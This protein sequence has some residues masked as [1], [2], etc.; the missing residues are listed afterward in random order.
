MD[1]AFLMDTSS[2]AAINKRESKMQLT[3]HIEKISQ[4]FERKLFSTGRRLNL[5]KYF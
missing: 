1:D 4:N 5:K 2:S 3:A